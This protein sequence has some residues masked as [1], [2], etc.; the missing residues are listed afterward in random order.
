MGGSRNE[1][2]RRQER[3]PVE[4]ATN[5]DIFHAGDG[6]RC[7][8]IAGLPARCRDDHRTSAVR[9][10][11]SGEFRAA[12]RSRIDNFNLREEAVAATSN[13]FHKAGTLGGVAEGLTDFADRF[14]EPVVEIHES[15]RG[16][17]LLLELLASYD[18]AGM[19]E[20]HRQDLEG[21]FLKPDSQAV[22]AQFASAKIQFENPKTEPPASADGLLAWQR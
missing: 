15:V 8:G 3:P 5:T 2:S 16:P 6:R 14:V 11:L 22:L 21:L 19:L 1:T 13:G 18:L 9:M 12:N 17:E 10:R 20:Q 4:G 7:L